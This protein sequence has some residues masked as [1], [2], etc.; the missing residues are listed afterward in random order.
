VATKGRTKVAT[1]SSVRWATGTG[2]S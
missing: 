2:C 1:N